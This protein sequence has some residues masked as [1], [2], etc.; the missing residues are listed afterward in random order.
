METLPIYI[1]LVFVLVT[2]LTVFLFYK[3]SGN[4]KTVLLIITG[5]LAVQTIPGLAGFYLNTG[6]VP[7]RFALLLL[8]P[9]ALIAVL[10]FTKKGKAF[11]DGLDLK[12]LTIL[13][14]IR[15]S[16]EMVLLWLA[17]HKTIP[18][19]MTFEGQNFDILSGLSAPVVYYFAFVKKSMGRTALLIWNFICLGLLIN[20]VVRAILAIPSP[21]QQLAFDQPNIAV[22]YFPFVWLPACV[23]PIVLFSHLVAIR[24]ILMERKKMEISLV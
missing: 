16:V 4:S 15:V 6:L 1:S 9:L 22:A 19:L 21:F 13:H 8:P 7:P 3:A 5:W 20:V 14:I 23:V 11:I 24:R 10:F 17:I 2:A 18:Y 12:T